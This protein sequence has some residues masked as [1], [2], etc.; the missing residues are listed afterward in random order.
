MEFHNSDVMWMLAGYV[1]GLCV[2]YLPGTK[3]TEGRIAFGTFAFVVSPILVVAAC[4]QDGV[5]RA[6]LGTVGM[7]LPTWIL[8]WLIT[9]GVRSLVARKKGLKR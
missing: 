1:A 5:G 6:L 7:F 4:F 9:F 8:G 2:A 3:S